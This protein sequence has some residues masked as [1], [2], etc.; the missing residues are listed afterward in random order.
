[1]NKNYKKH[2]EKELRS[3]NVTIWDVLM[4]NE[5]FI[6]CSFHKY[7]RKACYYHGKHG[8]AIEQYLKTLAY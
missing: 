3:Y 5:N 7:Y 2:L 1:M 4:L 8:G 6:M